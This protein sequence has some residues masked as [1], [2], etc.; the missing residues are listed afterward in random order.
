MAD[1]AAE[2]DTGRSEE[3]ATELVES[4]PLSYDGLLGSKEGLLGSNDGRPGSND[5]RTC[6]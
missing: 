1:D 4:G 5:G 3:V 2:A 6:A